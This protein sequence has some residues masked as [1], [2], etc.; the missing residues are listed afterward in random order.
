MS[1]RGSTGRPRGRPPGRGAPRTQIWEYE[2]QYTPGPEIYK[3]LHHVRRAPPV[4]T[5]NLP[6]TCPIGI[7][8]SLSRIFD[9]K[10]YQTT[11]KKHYYEVQVRIPLPSPDEDPATDQLRSS[12]RHNNLVPDELQ[13]SEWNISGKWR[14]AI[15]RVDVSRVLRLVSAR[16][17]ERFE[18]AEFRK[19]AELE[20]QVKKWEAE[21]RAAYNVEKNEAAPGAGRGSRL[22][23]GLGSGF[24]ADHQA[25]RRGRLPKRG[26]GRGRGVHQLGAN[27][28][29]EDGE[30]IFGNAGTGLGLGLGPIEAEVGSTASSTEEIDD[31]DEGEGDEDEDEDALQHP[32][33]IMLSSF[34]A[35]SA[36]PISPIAAGRGHPEVPDI[37][38]SDDPD[39]SDD[40]S[41]A[42]AAQQLAYEKLLHERQASGLGDERPAKKRRT[43]S[44]SRSDVLGAA[45]RLNLAHQI[46]AGDSD[47]REASSDRPSSADEEQDEEQDEE[48]VIESILEH[49]YQDGVKYYLVKWEGYDDASDWLAENDLEGAIELV[50][51]YNA[52]MRARRK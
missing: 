19:E 12:G 39:N 49:S 9:R 23:A 37:D 5:P 7:Q 28:A 11:P 50:D 3:M 30:T 4:V 36:L 32:S 45:R 48:Y 17:L 6:N 25:R 8:G 43:D 33:P 24:V 34:V 41:M 18:N 44:T 16:E 51:E 35:N 31:D 20:A 21:E 22:L 40:E 27:T 47:P 46:D 42:G 15:V 52:T 2:V 14:V 10:Q 26:R 29:R 38:D 13:G 1:R